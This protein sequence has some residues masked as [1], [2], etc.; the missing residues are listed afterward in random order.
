MKQAA[1]LQEELRELLEAGCSQEAIDYLGK[2][3]RAAHYSV[4]YHVPMERVQKAV[5]VKKMKACW[6]GDILWVE[7]RKL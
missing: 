2:P 6:V 1:A 3:I 5:S 7:D 4:K